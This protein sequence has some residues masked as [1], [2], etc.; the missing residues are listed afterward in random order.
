MGV[1][2]AEGEVIVKADAKGIPGQIRRDIEGGA[3]IVNAAGMSTGRSLLLGVGSVFGGN[4]L[5]D[6]ARG[7][8]ALIGAGVRA[9]F[10][11]GMDGL[12]LASNLN[13]SL[14]AVNVTFGEEV[15]GQLGVISRAAPR[16]LRVTQTA[17]NEYAVRFSAFA[18]NIAGD[19]GDVVA[20]IDQI[21][22][23]GADFASVYNMEVADALA[24]FQSGLAGETEPL[25][26]FGLDLSAA[27]V[28]S[29]AYATGIGTIGKELTEAEKIQARWSLILQQ[30]S[31]VQGDA[32][33][34]AG[35]FAN[36]QRALAINLEEAQTKLGGFLLGPANDLLVLANDSLIPALG[37]VVSK[38]GPELGAALE[39]AM[40]AIGNLADKVAPLLADLLE[41]GGEALPDVIN[42]MGT[43]VE[44]APEWIDFFAGLD[45][46]VRDLD[47]G[48][49]G[50]QDAIIQWRTE[51][52]WS[53]AEITEH[54]LDFMTRE[55]HKN[56]LIEES[57][58]KASNATKEYWLSSIDDTVRE[59]NARGQEFVG[60]GQHYGDGLAQGIYDRR[61]TV[62]EAARTVA[63]DAVF[64]SR[65]AMGIESPSKEGK[66]IGRYYDEGIALGIYEDAPMITRAAVDVAPTATKVIE[67]MPS[68]APAS[69][70]ASS[71]GSDV[72]IE[73]LTLTIDA[74]SVR[75]LN[76]L[77]AI[78]D[79]LPQVARTGRSRG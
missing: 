35:E 73:N 46:W 22:T 47:A 44:H 20:T 8:G 1:V 75:E 18:R 65:Q 55:E 69:R 63:G 36:Q 71:G 60:I 23:R 50:M 54:G 40:P 33:N 61:W 68:I 53:Y 21:T 43:A 38:I 76:D 26:K 64:A 19:G 9:G 14:N 32:T 49:R 37:G 5:T 48:Y 39:D 34:T 4:I 30:T 25:R 13:E 59:L 58:K 28:E 67:H 74:S 31:A 66:K 56:W 11:Y 70:S 42:E 24:L 27:A 7:G 10:E 12:A 51:Q 17:F 79:S 2:V 41:M 15:A 45:G 62:A 3:G 77:L 6:L 57:N 29:H 52:V 72:H 78:F 16:E